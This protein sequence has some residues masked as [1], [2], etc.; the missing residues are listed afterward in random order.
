MGGR[1]GGRGKR[2]K[3]CFFTANGIT[4]IDYKDV[5]LLKRFVSERGKILPRRVTGT[6]AKYQR[7]LTIAIK[8]ARQMALLPYVAE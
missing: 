3:V 1:K 8:R 5:D 7:K 6:S 2:R 4:H